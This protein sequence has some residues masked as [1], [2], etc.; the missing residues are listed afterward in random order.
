M[1][2]N[3]V[4]MV[5]LITYKNGLLIESEYLAF[6]SL[7]E[8][9]CL[10]I[11][12]IVIRD[13][14]DLC[15]EERN[16]HIYYLRIQNA[17]LDHIPNQISSFLGLKFLSLKK[18]RIKSIYREL[19]PLKELEWLD[20][21]ENSI[22]SAPLDLIKLKNLVSLDL[23]SNF[24][25]NF[26][27]NIKKMTNLSDLFLSNNKIKEL[28]LNIGEF[29]HLEVLD[30]SFNQIEVLPK[31][32]KNLTRLFQL[33]LFANRIKTIEY[34]PELLED[35][36]VDDGVINDNP[37]H[38]LYGFKNREIFTE[39]VD[40]I[41]IDFFEDFD[42][43]KGV[44]I[45]LKNGKSDVLFDYYQASTTDLLLKLFHT[46]L[47]DDIEI[48]RLVWEADDTILE[49]MDDMKGSNETFGKNQLV[50]RIYNNIKK[51]KNS[52]IQ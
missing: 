40:T 18:N 41:I 23:S 7:E 30:L 45:L 51:I 5:Q 3:E 15:F 9:Y 28:P 12:R 39:F 36:L 47:L 34:L 19:N 52:T 17:G 24:I 32:F 35:R 8:E 27:E 13:E 1:E 29:Q 49:K 2:K 46:G 42:L 10:S 43:P 25:Q 31:S 48:E 50:N 4:I 33:H 26:P 21:S 37:I 22:K 6:K 44:Q 16:G 14:E 38:D 11:P 20:L